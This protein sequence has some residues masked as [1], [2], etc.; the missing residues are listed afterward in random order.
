MPLEP[1]A[2]QM[3]TAAKWA[4]RGGRS[5]SMGVNAAGKPQSEF[6]S[7][8]VRGKRRFNDAW[9]GT[10]REIAGGHEWDLPGDYVL[11][12]VRSDTLAPFETTP[13][14]LQHLAE[15]GAEITSLAATAIPNKN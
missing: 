11:R 7:W 15:W 5:I 3:V 14:E 12:W 10:H 2:A 1:Q 8:G 4:R 6:E 9:L 13:G